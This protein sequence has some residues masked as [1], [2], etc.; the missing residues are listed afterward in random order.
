MLVRKSVVSRGR[1]GKM[2]R[3]VEVLRTRVLRGV[4]VPIVIGVVEFIVDECW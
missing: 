3:S 1:I 2:A 4:K